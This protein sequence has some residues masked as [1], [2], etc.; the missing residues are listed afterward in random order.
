MIESA[1]ISNGHI[2]I[3]IRISKNEN[4]QGVIL[5]LPAMGVKAS[6]YGSMLN[7]VGN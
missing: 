6:Y 7:S 5:I 4:S 2:D 1:V 3:P